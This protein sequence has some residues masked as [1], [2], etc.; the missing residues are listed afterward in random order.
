MGYIYKQERIYHVFF[1]DGNVEVFGGVSRPDVKERLISM[2]YA[3]EMIH[4][5]EPWQPARAERILEN[6]NG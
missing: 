5:I 3:E 1:I 2:G 6:Q 4:S